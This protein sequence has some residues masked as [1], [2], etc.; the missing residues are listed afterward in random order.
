MV[1]SP[2]A[3]MKI[4]DSAVARPSMRW[5]KRAIDVLAFECLEHAV[6]IA[7]FALGAA[8]RSGERGAA[9]EPG[10]SDRRI[11]RT[12]AIDDKK[13]LGLHLAVGLREFLDAKHFVEHD[14]AGA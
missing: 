4:A 2:R 13:S 14:D 11:R 7:V 5:Q 1:R 3:F 9:A 8:E 6:A 12:A 10:D